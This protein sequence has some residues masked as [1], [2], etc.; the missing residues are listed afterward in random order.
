MI[1]FFPKVISN[2]GLLLYAVSLGMVSIAF[3]NY[4]MD[5]YWL[6][7]GVMEVALFFLL[8]NRLSQDW[9]NLSTKTFERNLFWVALLLR[10]IWLIF[11]YFF[12]IQQSGQPYEFDAAD[13]FAYHEDAEWLADQPWETT[14]NYLFLSRTSYSDSGYCLYLTFIYKIFG[15]NVF[16]ARL[17]K[18]L[19]SAYSAVLLY[20]LASRTLGE[21]V[22]RL[23]AVFCMLMPNLIIYCGLH[24]KET[25]MLFLL[26]AFLERADYALRAPMVKFWDI[27]IPLLIA[28]AIFTFR[29]PLGAVALFAFVTGVLVGTVGKTRRA[30]R[31]RLAIWIVLAIVVLAGGTV[32]SE[33]EQYWNQRGENQEAKR[34]FQTLRGNQWARYATA[35]VMAP[36]MFVIPFSTMVDTDQENQML[37]HGG[38][39]VRNFMGV[40]VIITLVNA[41]FVK[42]NWRDFALIGSFVVGYLGVIAMSGFAN[43]ERFVLPA[44]PILIIS[45]AYGI[46][47]LNAKSFRL[48]KLWYLIVPVMEIGWAIFKIGS[49][50]LLE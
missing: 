43:S 3:M 40:F 32:M 42:K 10:V 24:L 19:L 12:Y 34:T 27:A 26:I 48:V 47:V 49:R 2:K 46:S 20:R 33:V 23:S 22:G 6:L 50:G 30:R 31:V 41:L 15:P 13:S 45:W 4:V 17:L 39:Y 44:L 25:E 28:V 5:W 37:M 18:C 21:Q 29:S 36:I 16:V 9:Q 35:P 8:S 7:L 38:N 1:S 14:W 11:S